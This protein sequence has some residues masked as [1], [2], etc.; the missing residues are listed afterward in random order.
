MSDVVDNSN[1]DWLQGNTTDI[2]IVRPRRYQHLLGPTEGEGDICR[3][4]LKAVNIT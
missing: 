2:Y 3:I 1:I 4:T